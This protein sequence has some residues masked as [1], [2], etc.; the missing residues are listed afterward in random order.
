MRKL[1]LIIFFTLLFTNLFGQSRMDPEMSSFYVKHT[2][3][4]KNCNPEKSENC[5][6]LVK[7]LVQKA[8]KEKVPYLDHLYFSI[9]YWYVKQSDFDKAESYAKLALENPHPE[10][11]FRSDLDVYN[12][13][14]NCSYYK[15][16]LKKAIDYYVKAARILEEDPPSLRLGYLYSNIATLLGES[17][18]DNKQL[19][20]LKKSY[21]ILD[22]LKDTK[23]IATVASNLALTNYYTK[24]TAQVKIWAEKA[25]KHS[26][27]NPDLVAESQA[28]NCL[29][30]IEKNPKTSLELAEKSVNAAKELGNPIYL[31]TSFSQMAEVLN[32]LGRNKEALK[33][34]EESIQYAEEA[35]DFTTLMRSSRIAGNLHLENGNHSIA[36]KHLN[37]YI[38]LNDSI[39]S[40]DI[41]REINELNTK[42]ETEK[43][44][45]QIAE[46]ELKIQKQNTNLWIA[47]L[48]GILL[49]T[50][51]GGTYY[52]N[53][54][55]HTI[56]L[57]QLQKEKENAILNSFIQGEERER[58]RISHELHD[59][60]AAMIG[61]AK[62]SLESLPHLPPEKQQDHLA[63]IKSILDNTHADVRHIAH[64]LLPTVL[65]KDGIIKATIHFAKEINETKLV[66]VSVQDDNSK[67][68]ELNP[69]LQLMLFR[70]I[71]ELINNIIKHSQA[72]NA[73]I[74]FSRNENGLHI[75]VTD[76]GI[77]FDGEIDSGNQGLYSISQRIKSIGGNFKF[78]KKKDRGMQAIAELKVD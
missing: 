3:E 21:S 10:P 67:A 33:F 17:G 75:E 25:L 66:Q 22:E 40:K 30:R 31:A 43:K 6:Q 18:N 50:I 37:R 5:D 49:V 20:Y 45:K 16:D 34:A 12:I 52:F 53:R 44:E 47:I 35:D 13:L 39:A 9:A 78:T 57:A 65:E 48:G 76:D 2:E 70:V 26:Q 1:L 14:G 71:Q 41:S 58:N 8:K 74:L 62:M 19:E 32:K 23:F 73:Q 24:D 59:G 7:D 69:Q 42:Y 68:N 36:S 51:L 54:K 56:R 60:V 46:Q 4:L 28:Y 72:Q 55:N 38:S 61:A 27:S 11:K 63:K 77:G 15:A 29:S 64:N